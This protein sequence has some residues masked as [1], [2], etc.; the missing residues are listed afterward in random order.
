MNE[1]LNYHSVDDLN[2]LSLAEL[3]ALWELVPTDRQRR[4]KAVYDREVKNAGAAGSDA[5]EQQVA[6][7]LLT[8][9]VSTALVPIGSRWARTPGRIQE[10]AK[11]NNDLVAPETLDAE[12][13][14]KKPPVTLFAVVG[15]VF[16]IIVFLIISRLGGRGDKVAM[17][18]TVTTTATHTAT[19]G[20]SPTPTPIALEDQ[21]PVIRGGDSDRAAAYPVNLRVALPNA[22][23]PR[24]FVV[25]RRIVQTAEWNFDT[26]PDTASYIAGLTVRPV[27]GV[28]F[29]PENAALFGNM[30]DGTTFTL[31]MNTGAALRFTFEQR[32]EVSRSD[33]GIFRQIGPGL[34]LVLIGERGLDNAPTATRQVITATYAPDQELNRNGALMGLL[35]TLEPTA[36]PTPAPTLPAFSRLDVTLISVETTLGRITAKLRI[37]NGQT[38]SVRIGRGMIW[39]ALGYAPEPQGPRLTAQGL[40]P[41]DLLPGQAADVTIYWAWAGEPFGSLG[42]GE[43]RYNVEIGK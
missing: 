3:N 22:R 32:L 12:R 9:Y 25:Q 42:V 7:E 18:L 15:V 36:T 27:M 6:A 5:L 1:T 8:R 16:V 4:Y 14:P 21:D 37:F 23:Q 20:R 11:Q 34:V 10:T 41:F 19:P 17:N 30:T 35:P 26:N 24:V 33:T 13:K 43:Y 38:E 39:L 28:P 29:S 31:Q 40:T 2:E